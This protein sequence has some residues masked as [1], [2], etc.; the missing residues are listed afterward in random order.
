M[1]IVLRQDVDKVGKRGDIVEVA[2]GYARNFL[3]PRGFAIN[4]TDGIAAQAKAMRAAR[5]KADAKN[6]AA[7][8]ERATKIEGATIKVEARVG[9][10]GKLFGSVTNVEIADALQAQ[11]SIDIDR[12]QLDLHQPI[13]TVGS[14]V[15]PVRLHADVRANITVEVVPVQK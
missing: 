6:L 1:Q 2:E 11:A 7:A 13:R 3:I 14:H 12:R 8:Q 5:D 15:V 4:S 10:E 9:Q